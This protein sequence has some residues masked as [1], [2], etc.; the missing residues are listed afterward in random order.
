MAKTNDRTIYPNI[1]F[2]SLLDFLLGTKEANGKTRSFP[3][4]SVIQLI[5]GVNGKNNIQFQFSDGTDED[6]DYLTPGAL[7]TN[8]NQT[9]VGNFTELIFNKETVFPI[10]LS[11]LFNKLG[12]LQ[13]VILKLENPEDPNNFFNFKVVSFQDHGVY[14]VF[15]VEEFNE[16]Y[17]GDFINEK[18]Y[19]LYFTISSDIPND[20]SKVVYFNS[21]NPASATIFDLNN[22]P[23]IND[24]SLKADDKNLYVANDSTT[25]VYNTNTSLYETKEINTAS[26]NFYLAGT[27]TDA[28]SSKTAPIERPGTVGGSPAT[29]ANHFVTKAQLDALKVTEISYACSDEV[30]DLA[31]GTLITFRMPISLTLTKVKLSLNVA[32]TVSKLIVDV[33][34]NGVSIFSTLSSIDTNQTTSVGASVPAVISNPNLTDDSIITILTTQVGSGVAGKGLKVT[35]VG[36][37]I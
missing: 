5:N 13:N 1:D 25:W 27:T 21:T 15:G 14:F 4:Q 29:A 34:R 33:R 12:E 9:S 20:F 7:F 24:N 37:K 32:P 3:L 28:G 6:I 17:L 31:V 2:P 23:V 18:I 22:P 30:S 19:S 8:N 36:T 16:L 11:Q 26:S 35:F 10:D